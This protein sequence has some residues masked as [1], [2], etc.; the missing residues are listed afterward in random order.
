M[1]QA[2]NVSVVE[3]V[4]ARG[5]LLLATV[6][7]CIMTAWIR[8]NACARA[9]VVTSGEAAAARDANTPSAAVQAPP[10]VCRTAA[11][12]PPAAATDDAAAATSAGSEQGSIPPVP[13]SA[14]NAPIT[15]SPAH[16]S[17]IE[18]MDGA[19]GAGDSLRSFDSFR[20][21]LRAANNVA[22]SR[23]ISTAATRTSGEGEHNINRPAASALEGSKVSVLMSDPPRD[24]DCAN[25]AH[26]VSQTSRRVRAA[27]VATSA[28]V[29]A[30]PA[31]PIDGGDS[32]TPAAP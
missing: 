22:T 25:A 28:S 13:P 8:C 30:I 21:C 15:I 9:V 14:P 12:A 23:S 32:K 16:D 3:S 17:T 29:N 10:R 5:P 24:G 19:D 26:H 1:R 18:N 11:A 2:S 31:R 20:E 7:S 4:G 27:D 6:P